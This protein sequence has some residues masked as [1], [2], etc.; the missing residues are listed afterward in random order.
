M[1]PT[2]G[3]SMIYHDIKRHA[4]LLSD[5]S[6][7]RVHENRSLAITVLKDGLVVADEQQTPKEFAFE[8]VAQ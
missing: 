6:E 3:G 8:E 2:I 7:L 1:D 5:Y 4:G